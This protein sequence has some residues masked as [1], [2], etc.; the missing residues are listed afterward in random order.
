MLRQQ[1]A[2]SLGLTSLWQ[3]LPHSLS[4][5]TF[6]REEH[7]SMKAEL[8]KAFF[9]PMAM[10]VPEPLTTRNYATCVCIDR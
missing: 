9:C 10:Q 6:L 5:R 3:V 7:D 8:Q 4:W 2:E 1:L